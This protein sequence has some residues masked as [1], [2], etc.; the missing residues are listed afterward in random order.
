MGNPHCTLD[1]DTWEIDN[2]LGETRARFDEAIDKAM[3]DVEEADIVTDG[4]LFDSGAKAELLATMR[5]KDDLE[6]GDGDCVSRASDFAGSVGNST[7]RSVNLKRMVAT[8]EA[9]KQ[10]QDNYTESE[11]KC[12]EQEEE[13][14]IAQEIIL[15]YGS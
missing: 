12:V 4:I 9:N 14:Q 11:K 10:L 15:S 8:K 3:S 2:E 13:M 5:V 7:N 1:V 6:F